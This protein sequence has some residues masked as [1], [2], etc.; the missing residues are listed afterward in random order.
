LAKELRDKVTIGEVRPESKKVTSSFK[1]KDFP[2]IFAIN[3]PL[4]YIGTPYTGS[5]KKDDLTQFI[6]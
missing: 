6:L 3:E 4:N 1:V 2:K 5:L